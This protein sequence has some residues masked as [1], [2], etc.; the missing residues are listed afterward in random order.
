MSAVERLPHRWLSAPAWLRL[1]VVC[2]VV[3]AGPSVTAAPP[4]SAF[5]QSEAVAASAPS[6]GAGV[7]SVAT[8]KAR[9][10]VG[11][12]VRVTVR[13]ASS[14]PIYAPLGQSFCTIITLQREEG[15]L[16]ATE[17]AC[18]GATPTAL[19]IAAQGSVTGVL[20]PSGSPSAVQ[21]P[22]VGGPVAPQTLGED[23]RLLPTASPPRP[24][25]PAT[26]VP[27][28]ILTPAPLGAPE[29][30]PNSTLQDPLAEGRYCIQFSFAADS[31][32]GA[33]QMAPPACFVNAS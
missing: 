7:V 32:A 22:A 28:G 2:S 15:G 26:E 8:D 23:L 3:A 31:P 18:D 9:Y 17:G 29:R 1:L 4:A 24:G 11:E 12:S 27:Q 19:A 13:N 20:G 21:G 33:M 16:W 25:Q 6:D 30:L 5:A 10:A 14:R